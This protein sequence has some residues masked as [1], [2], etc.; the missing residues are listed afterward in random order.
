MKIFIPA[1]IEKSLQ[2]LF[3]AVLIS[4]VLHA[5]ETGSSSFGK[6]VIPQPTLPDNAQ[7]CVEPVDVM[8]RN[9]M[10]F[11]QHQRD[12]TVLSGIRTEKYSLT[13][14]IDCH[15]QVSGNG[16]IVR[17]ESPEYFCTSCHLYAAVDIDCFEC[18]SDQPSA[19]TDR[20]SRQ[21]T[22][23]ELLVRVDPSINSAPLSH[24]TY[25]SKL[26]QV[27]NRDY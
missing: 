13:G 8:R 18:H 16:N 5:S 23:I 7:Q 19:T 27:E 21:F 3:L 22:T 17:A 10:K 11:L 1:I 4:P 20:V 12:E 26:Q 24:S 15:V 25:Q 9:H 14:C 6:V 2:L